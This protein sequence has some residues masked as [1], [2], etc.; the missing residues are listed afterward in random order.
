MVGGSLPTFAHVLGMAFLS[1]GLLGGGRRAALRWG[2]A[3]ALIDCAWEFLSSGSNP[4]RDG[5]MRAGARLL[6]SSTPLNSAADGGDIAAACLGF[7]AA[8][9]IAWGVHA[10]AVRAN[11]RSK[12]V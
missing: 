4:W 3:W 1:S 10:G 7:G 9:A 6:G 5:L 2:A 12:E 11:Q 8:V